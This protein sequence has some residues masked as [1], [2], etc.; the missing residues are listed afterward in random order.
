MYFANVLELIS[1]TSVF[2]EPDQHNTEFFWK[3]RDLITGGYFPESN[4]ILLTQWNPAHYPFFSLEM[5]RILCFSVSALGV[6]FFSSLVIIFLWFHWTNLSLT[7][8]IQFFFQPSPLKHSLDPVPLLFFVA[9]LI[10]FNERKQQFS[11]MLVLKTYK[12]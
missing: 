11:L 2:V 1:P 3:H 5:T 8:Y 10:L 4:S 9:K 6:S 12:V 7:L